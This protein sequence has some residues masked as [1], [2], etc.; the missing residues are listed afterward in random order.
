MRI[1]HSITLHTLMLLSCPVERSLAWE[2]TPSK[3]CAISKP[4]DLR[5]SA[6]SQVIKLSRDPRRLERAYDLR[7]LAYMEQRRFANA[8]TDFSEVIRLNP[9]IAGYF[10]NRQ[11]AYKSLG[12][13]DAALSDANKAVQLAPTHTFVFYSRGNVYMER[14]QYRLA[15]DDFLAGL[16]LA[17]TDAGL[18]I[19]LGD[20]YVASTRFDDGIAQ[21]STVLQQ[22]SDPQALRQRG[23]AYAS[24][25]RTADAETDLSRF[26]ELRPGDA[27]VKGIRAM[28][29]KDGGASPATTT[30]IPDIASEN[31]RVALVI[32]NGAYKNAP[33]SNPAVDADLV[34]LSLRNVGFDVVEVKDVDFVGFDKAL[35]DFV[36][37]EESADIALF[38]FAGHGFAI[39][40]DDLRPRNYLM[41]T[42]ADM[43]STS[44]A[45]L[46]RDGISIDEIIHRISAA[47]KVTLAF[48]DACRNDPFHRGGG[49][50]GFERIGVGATRQ[51]YIGMS[52]TLGRTALDGDDGKGS[53]FAT[54]FVDTMT[55][56]GQRID[57]AFR[58]LRDEVSQRT[59][60]KQ[61]PEVLQDNLRQGALVLVKAH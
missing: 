44:D 51:V 32:G 8:L 12:L 15:I 31:R 59:D 37:K 19:R 38:Y 7:G 54:A 17:P 14:K 21:Y 23:L 11:N 25:G 5:V 45:V 28:L 2:T 47:A 22:N 53:P 48:V 33:L 58:A 49:D 3:D 27:E 57:D 1:R 13:L 6:C 29:A 60:G 18:R 26:D 46:R 42:S 43:R 61:E 50:R 10:D 39:S 56:P 40:G 41:S 34:S 52:T 55:V 16:R 36:S 9:T 24:L 4:A 30:P 35:T 20:A